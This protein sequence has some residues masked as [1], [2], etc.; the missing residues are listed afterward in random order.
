MPDSPEG[1]IDPR[2]LAANGDLPPVP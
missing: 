2:P 1:R